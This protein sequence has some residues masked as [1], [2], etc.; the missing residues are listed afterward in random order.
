[1]AENENMG[2][3]TGSNQETPKTFTQDELNAIVQDRLN[4]E[5]AKY[6]DYSE[7]KEKAAAFDEARESEKTELQN[8]LER[9]EKAESAAAALQAEKERAAAVQQIAASS[10]VDAG[11][12]AMMQ[13]STTEQIQANADVLKAKFAAVPKYPNITDTGSGGNTSTM[14][15]DQIYA[16]K[17]DAERLKAIKENIDLWNKE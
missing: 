1:M 4:R 17:S 15:K 7:L 5:R 6:A 2:N 14:T 10:G 11:L 16:I 12:L 8:A 9:A 3:E 13:G